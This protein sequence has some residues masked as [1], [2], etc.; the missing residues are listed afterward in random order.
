MT[1]ARLGLAVVA[2][3]AMRVALV[4][5]GIWFD[6]FGLWV[7]RFLFRRHDTEGGINPVQ[8][9]KEPTDGFV[10]VVALGEIELAAQDGAERD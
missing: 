6:S 1:L 3:G 9:V 8:V 4:D 2:V 5:F 7:L 10:V